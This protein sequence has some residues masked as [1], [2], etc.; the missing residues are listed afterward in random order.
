MNEQSTHKPLKTEPFAHPTKPGERERRW[1]RR[2]HY[3]LWA[4][5]AACLL[6]A[7]NVWWRLLVGMP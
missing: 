4:L 1:E 6:L 7:A 3:V 2:V 5:A